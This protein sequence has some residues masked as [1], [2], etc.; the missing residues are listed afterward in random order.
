MQAFVC[1]IAFF[2][3]FNIRSH[4]YLFKSVQN[5]SYQIEHIAPHD[6]NAYTQG[7]VCGEQALFESTGLYG[8]SSL[9][10]YSWPS[11]QT[12]QYHS[13]PN[14]F[15][16]EGL[17]MWLGKLWQLTWKEH[18]V[19]SYS[20]KSF[21]PTRAFRYPGQG[22]GLTHSNDHFIMSDG[23]HCLQIRDPEKFNLLTKKC[24]YRY[25]LPIGRI[26]SIDFH[27]NLLFANLLPSD[28]I[29]IIDYL[30]SS[31]IK[32]IDLSSLRQHLGNPESAEVLNGVCALSRDHLIVTG[33]RWDKIFHIKLLDT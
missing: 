4:A 20:P 13:M 19:F 28:N 25:N 1:Y 7:L 30:T 12:L 5:P 33:K 8:E 17:T 21:I 16:G 24:I 10:Q 14:H 22:W 2:L 11:M 32:I 6:P 18:V 27:D 3:I 9:R 31:I 15:F 23:S 26:N 29:A